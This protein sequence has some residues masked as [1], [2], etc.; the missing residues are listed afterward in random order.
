MGT[1]AILYISTFKWGFISTIFSSLGRLSLHIMGFHKLLI[2]PL[3]A[4]CIIPII[5]QWNNNISVQIIFENQLIT[6]IVLIIIMFFSYIWGELVVK[7]LNF[8]FK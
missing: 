6:Y 5:H 7:K 3:Y 1:T 8:I 4:Y 2:S